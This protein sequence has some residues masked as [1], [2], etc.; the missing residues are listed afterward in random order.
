M[1]SR[2]PGVNLPA[3]AKRFARGRPKLREAETLPDGDNLV[4]RALRVP[5]NWFH[6]WRA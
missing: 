5:T 4:V 1:L 2:L 3:T 6:R